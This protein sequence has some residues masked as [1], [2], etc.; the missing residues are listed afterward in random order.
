MTCHY[1]IVII[2]IISES[3]SF[4]LVIRCNGIT[5]LSKTVLLYYTSIVSKSTAHKDTLCAECRERWGT[6]LLYYTN[7]V[8]SKVYYA[9]KAI[10]AQNVKYGAED[11]A[12]KLTERSLVTNIDCF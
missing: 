2:I 8:V 9:P 10:R 7:N 12:V 11:R 1:I 3:Y 4:L 5:I 6:V